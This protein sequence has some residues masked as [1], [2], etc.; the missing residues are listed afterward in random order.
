MWNGAEFI[1]V[2]LRYR[3]I[4]GNVTSRHRARETV[5]LLKMGTPDF[6]PSRVPVIMN[7]RLF[8]ISH[9]APVHWTNTQRPTNWC[10]EETFDDYRPLSLYREWRHG[11]IQGADCHVAWG[12]YYC[13][14]WRGL[15]RTPR[16]RLPCGRWPVVANVWYTQVSCWR[17]RRQ[18][19]VR[20]SMCVCLAEMQTRELLSQ[21]TWFFFFKKYINEIK[22]RLY[23]DSGVMMWH[24]QL[25][26]TWK[27]QGIF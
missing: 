2:T 25:W 18:P 9:F 20:E 8:P 22:R 11:I 12:D 4:S 10:S 14:F 17:R 13:L 1:H 6:I 24:W 27:S 7:H 15:F 23:N 21:L 19:R 16:Y 26:R 5:E 3:A